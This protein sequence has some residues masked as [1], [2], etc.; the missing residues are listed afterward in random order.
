MRVGERVRVRP[1]SPAA[2]EWGLSA[3]VEGIVLC[4][5]RILAR[6]APEPDRVDV[7]LATGGIVW[8]GSAAD[9]ETFEG[10]AVKAPPV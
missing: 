4:Q 10:D 8:G 5:Y 6:G 9:F 1:A 3:P 2:R 7:R